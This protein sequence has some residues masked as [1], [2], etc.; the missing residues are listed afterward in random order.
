MTLC[1]LEG[2]H[3]QHQFSAAACSSIISS[4]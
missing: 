1:A 4:N 3:F 2:A